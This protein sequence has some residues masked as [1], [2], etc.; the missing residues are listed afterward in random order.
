MIL[1]LEI[2][3]LSDAELRRIFKFVYARAQQPLFLQSFAAALLCA[4]DEQDFRLLRYAAVMFVSKYNLGCY[5][6]E[7]GPGAERSLSNGG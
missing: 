1:D 3:M 5:L 7:E 6:C 2:L 4:E